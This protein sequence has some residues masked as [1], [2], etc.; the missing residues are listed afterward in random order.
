MI[1]SGVVFPGLAAISMLFYVFS[2]K[3][4]FCAWFWKIVPI[5]LV[6]YYALSWYFDF[7]LYREPDY[8]PVIIVMATILGS[9]MLLPA[10]Y[11]TF[12]FGYTEDELE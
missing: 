10:V 4:N 6:A 12:K 11:L 1:I 7:I 9:L 2:Y 5:T 8:T 3:P